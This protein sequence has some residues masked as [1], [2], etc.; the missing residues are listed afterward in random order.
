M[1][2]HTNTVLQASTAV[3]DSA[4]AAPA[5]TM[6]A[7]L[8]HLCMPSV[9]ARFFFASGSGEPGLGASGAVR[10]GASDEEL[11][12]G[13]LAAA[14]GGRV[15]GGGCSPTRLSR[16]GMTTGPTPGEPTPGCTCTSNGEGPAGCAGRTGAGC[17]GA[18]AG[19]D[20]DDDDDADADAAAV[21]SKRCRI[22]RANAADTAPSST[23]RRNALKYV[24]HCSCK[25]SRAASASA[26]S[27]GISGNVA[28][29]MRHCACKRFP[30]ANASAWVG[31][32]GSSDI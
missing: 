30:I 2:A 28:K 10:G 8:S 11:A 23:G 3:V 7:R 27:G 13:V 25:R 22:E 31:S 9:A 4:A 26:W 6:A 5:A 21:A 14:F 20:D 18:G 29:Y 32:E 12:G 19:A 17:A 24:R 16:P 15:F 1:D